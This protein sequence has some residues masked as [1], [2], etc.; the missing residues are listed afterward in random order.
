LQNFPEIQSA[1]YD[2]GDNEVTVTYLIPS[3]PTATASGASV[4]PLDV[5]FYKA[6]ADDQE[7]AFPLGDDEYDPSDYSACGSPP[8]A[9]TATFP[10]PSGVTLSE[11]DDVVA[12]A[13]DDDGNTSEFSGTSQQLPVE[14]TSFEGTRTQ[15][16]VRLTWATASE[17]N[18]AGFRIE[19]RGEARRGKD[20]PWTEIGF[21]DGR[22]TTADGQE[23]R[24]TDPDLSYTADSIAYRLEQVDIDGST[25]V[26][27]PI[28][29][30]R[31]RPNQ[32]A[33]RKVSPNP[34]REQVTVRYAVPEARAGM[35]KLRL[36]DVLGQQVRTVSSAAKA[37]RHEMQLNVDDLTSGVYFLR[38]HV[39]GTVETQRFT[40]VQ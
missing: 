1:G 38:L 12:T 27:E 2:A 6:D 15:H 22:G 16:G 10:P 31:S 17:T 8:C 37:G 32:L 30:E 34:A 29:V 35:G 20:G 24:F 40:V 23:Y 14:F 36:Y 9:V 26:T 18:N 5:D 21:V 7:G 39:G 3:D 33:L 11:S 19:R 28:V 25:Q 13:T 4:Y